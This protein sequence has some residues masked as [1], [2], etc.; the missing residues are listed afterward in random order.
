MTVSIIV[1]CLNNSKTHCHMSM[2]CLD[3]IV[4]FTDPPYELIIVDPSP[5]ESIRDDYKTLGLPQFKIDPPEYG[6]KTQENV[7][8]MK[9]KDDPGYTAGMN[10]AAKRAEG[11]VLVFIQNDV[12]VR[13]GW[14]N[15]L[16]YYVNKGFDVV[17]P[18][19]APRDRQYVLDSY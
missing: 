4:K 3:H 2:L 9:L 14:L 17:Y 16:L 8:W 13:E 11:D 5:K 6:I 12:F 15:G 7:T 10:I 18:D 1:S 19:Q